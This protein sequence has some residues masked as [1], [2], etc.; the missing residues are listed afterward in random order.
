MRNVNPRWFKNEI[1]YW[2]TMSQHTTYDAFWK[3]RNLLPHLRKVPPAVMTVGGWYDAEDLYGT[4]NTYRAVEKQNPGIFNVIVVGPWAH[5]GWAGA[6]GS[7]LGDAT[8][9]SNTAAFFQ[10]KIELTFFNHFLKGKGE[11]KLPEAYVFETGRN[12]WHQFDAWPPRGTARRTLY[13]GGKGTLC[14]EPAKDA[15]DAHD[16]FL[17]DPNHP[18]PYTDAITFGMRREYMTG[19]QRFASRRP[20]VLAYQTP[21]LTE[22]LMLAGPLEAELHVAT[23]GTDADWVVKLIDVYPPQRRQDHGRL[24][25]DGAQRSHPRPIPR[26]LREAQAIRAGSARDDQA[27]APGRAA[28]VQE[29]APHHGAGLLHV[30]PAGRSQSAEI[31][32]KYL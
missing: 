18:V 21:P 31:C 32:T 26:Q 30:V 29:G 25:D 6:D 7:R 5:G 13:L 28:H 17:S 2:N 27:A 19:D 23:T 10:E 12:R 8:F 4:F 24:P 1:A 16:T 14:A 9:G 22:D 3:A 20:D 11:N 15:A